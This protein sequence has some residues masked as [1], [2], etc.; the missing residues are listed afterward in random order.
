[1]A[2]REFT[3]GSVQDC[4]NCVTVE[5]HALFLALPQ[6]NVHAFDATATESITGPGLFWITAGPAAAAQE[7]QRPTSRT[8]AQRHE[9]HEA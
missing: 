6:M 7:M 9:Q 1:M 5:V 8:G 4:G 2:A 3:T